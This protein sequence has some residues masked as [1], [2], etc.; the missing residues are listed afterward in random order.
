MQVS[1]DDCRSFICDGELLFFFAKEEVERQ[2]RV[3]YM[4]RCDI[5]NP[6]F[7]YT[8][9]FVLNTK[10]VTGA[11]NSKQTTKYESATAAMHS[12]AVPV[13][14]WINARIVPRS[15]VIPALL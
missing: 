13:T 10:D 4:N 9:Q 11:T 3:Y 15:F 7:N 14:K 6:K 12:T 1:C 8:C 2:T 5:P